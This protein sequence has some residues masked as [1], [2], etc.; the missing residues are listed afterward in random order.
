MAGRQEVVAQSATVVIARRLPL[1]A[2]LL[3]SWEHEGTDLGRYYSD[4]VDRM[5]SHRTVLIGECASQ[6]P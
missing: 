6:S 1:T 3:S 2:A 5:I 4:D